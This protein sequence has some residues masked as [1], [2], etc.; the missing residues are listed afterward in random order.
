LFKSHAI[1]DQA[2]FGAKEYLAKVEKNEG[3]YYCH[4]GWV[5]CILVKAT[6]AVNPRI[7]FMRD[8]LGHPFVS[9]RDCTKALGLIMPEMANV[10]NA[11]DAYHKYG[12]VGAVRKAYAL[13][14]AIPVR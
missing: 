5:G 4:D 14:E 7:K 3:R 8:P 6:L 12:R 9:H 1:K 13:L 10:Y 2:L 11:H